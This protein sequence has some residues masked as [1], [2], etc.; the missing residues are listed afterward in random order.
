MSTSNF[1]RDGGH[2]M[3]KLGLKNCLTVE[4]QQR[5]RIRNEEVGSKSTSDGG[6]TS[7]FELPHSTSDESSFLAALRCVYRSFAVSSAAHHTQFGQPNLAYSPDARSQFNL[8][9]SSTSPP[10]S[11]L[12]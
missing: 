1:W 3:R 11:L 8:P 10:S 2:Q 4:G 12:R 6:V 9:A 7:K 5:R